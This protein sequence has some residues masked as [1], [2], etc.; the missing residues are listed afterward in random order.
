MGLVIGWIAVGWVV[1]VTA[2]FIM[3]TAFPVTRGALQQPP[4]PL[5]SAE[6][7][8]ARVPPSALLNCHPQL[9]ISLVTVQ[10]MG[11]W[12]TDNYFK[13]FPGDA[14]VF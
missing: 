6:E 13:S 5:L 1:F 10:L 2:V 12:P 11:V 9:C 7:C 14:S 8:T 4:A 3:P